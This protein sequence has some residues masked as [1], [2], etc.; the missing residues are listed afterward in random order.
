MRLPSQI[1]LA[2]V[3]FSSLVFSQNAG[4][5]VG[6]PDAFQVRYAANIDIGDSFVSM[7]NTGTS[8]GNICANLYTFDPAEELIDCCTC[9]L[10][11]NSLYSLSV[12]N[13]LISNTLT[14]AIP[15]SLMVKIVASVSTGT[16]DATSVTPDLLAS[17]LR[18]WGTTIHPLPSANPGAKSYGVTETAFAASALA[19]TELA[20]IT[21]FCWF[22]NAIGGGYGICRGC[23]LG[24]LG[25]TPAF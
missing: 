11:P 3:S 5:T 16:C 14:P 1:A 17:G 25:A 7:T 12:R 13:S 18:A 15:T 9:T 20:H 8:G 22:I 24:G 6:P 21:S 4:Q 19:T 10:S 2:A 23:T